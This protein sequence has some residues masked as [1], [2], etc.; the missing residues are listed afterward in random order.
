MGEVDEYKQLSKLQ[1]MKLITYV[2]HLVFF[3]LKRIRCTPITRNCHIPSQ[4]E[5]YMTFQLT[6]DLNWYNP[7]YYISESLPN[8]FPSTLLLSENKGKENKSVDDI[9][10]DYESKLADAR[11]EIKEKYLDPQL[12][13]LESEID[14]N[15][16]EFVK[17]Y[18]EK[19]N[20][21]YSATSSQNEFNLN[22]V[23]AVSNQDVLKLKT[24]KQKNRIEKIEKAK[25]K[26]LVFKKPE[27]KSFP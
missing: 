11:N 26:T 7:D 14:D 16:S 1:N 24:E 18:K 25:F 27:N 5:T 2:F 21:L 10:A 19:I 3:T 20:K 17:R 23:R 6:Y 13:V 9:I 15:H 22:Q 12:V 8:E 4:N